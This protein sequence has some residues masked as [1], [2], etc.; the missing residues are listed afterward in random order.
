[1]SEL[2][3]ERIERELAD[4]RRRHV[5]GK[6]ELVDALAQQLSASR[7]ARARLDAFNAGIDALVVELETAGDV[8]PVCARL[9]AMGSGRAP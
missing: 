9:E 4:L 8:G 1:M 2:A 7:R 5:A 6:A 3:P